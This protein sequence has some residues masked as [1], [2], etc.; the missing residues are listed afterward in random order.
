M[1]FATLRHKLSRL[2]FHTL[3]LPRVSII[4]LNS[5]CKQ[6][7]PVSTPKPKFDPDKWL[8]KKIFSEIQKMAI[9]NQWVQNK[10]CKSNISNGKKSK[11]S[12]IEFQ[13]TDFMVKCVNFGKEIVKESPENFNS[14]MKKT[15][16]SLNFLHQSAIKYGIP[17]IHQ[18]H[19]ILLTVQSK[20]NR[21][22]QSTEFQD[23]KLNMKVNEKR[24]LKFMQAKLKQRIDKLS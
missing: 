6:S 12:V 17:L 10:V 22:V 16:L 11:F 24:A 21:M 3:P 9:K 20:I 8:Y 18:I 13:Q 23:F 5:N 15:H 2:L 4:R 19:N 14:L 1:A 7:S